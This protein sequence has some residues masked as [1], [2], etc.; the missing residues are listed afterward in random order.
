MR[1]GKSDDVFLFWDTASGLRH[2]QRKRRPGSRSG[3]DWMVGM[4]SQGR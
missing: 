3:C 4:M 2:C 1:G